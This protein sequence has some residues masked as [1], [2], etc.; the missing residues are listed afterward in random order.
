[1]SRGLAVRLPLLAVLVLGVWLWRSDFFPQPRELVLLLPASGRPAARVEVQLYSEGGDLLAREERA[2]Q[3]GGGEAPS[4]LRIE[5]SLKQ[6]RYPCRAFLRDAS[7]A[8]RALRGTADV[9]QQKSVEVE[10]R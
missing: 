4:V 8:E 1:M 3:P 7:G 10:L 2:F 5:L 6:G 9:G